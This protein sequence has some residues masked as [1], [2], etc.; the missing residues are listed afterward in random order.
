VTSML[1][2]IGVEGTEL[3]YELRGTGAR[4]PVVLIHW[5]V[6]ATWAEPLLDQ[7]S[8]AGRYQLLSYHRAGF[9]GSGQLKGPQPWPRTPPTAI[10]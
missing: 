1:N 7:P 2:R 3:E 10:S 8:L 5:G 9:A 4:E 6:A